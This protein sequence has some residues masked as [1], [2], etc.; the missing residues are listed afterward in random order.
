MNTNVLNSNKSKFAVYFQGFIVG[1]T[2]LLISCSDETGSSENM[3][4][5]ITPAVEAV[6]ARYGKSAINPEIKWNS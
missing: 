5:G 4:G 3:P 1:L 2:A 6:Q